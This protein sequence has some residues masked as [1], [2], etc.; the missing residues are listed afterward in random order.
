MIVI[1]SY[2]FVFFKKTIK[3][4]ILFLAL[5]QSLRIWDSMSG[6]C[7]ISLSGHTMSVSIKFIHFLKMIFKFIFFLKK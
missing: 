5:S 7:L 4:L 1:V 6:R 3:N 2:R